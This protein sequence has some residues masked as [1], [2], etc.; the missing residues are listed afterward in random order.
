M[1]LGDEPVVV[2][3]G[4]ASGIGAATATAFAMAGARVVIAD[5]DEAGARALALRLGDGGA[6][7][8]AVR[9]DVSDEADVATLFARVDAA[10]GPVTHLVNNAGIEIVGA[11]QD[12]AVA[13]YDRLFAVNARSVFLC[14][15]EA[16][17]RMIPRR[18]G[19]IVNLASVASFKTWPGDGAYSASK[20]AVLALTKAFAADLAPYAIRVN[21]VAPAIV[22][23]PMTERSLDAEADRAAGRRRREAL[24]PLDRLARPQEIADAIL[25]LAGEES[26]FTTGACL[27]IDGGLLA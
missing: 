20:A 27:T 15:R 26:A 19:A 25:F 21:A 1:R 12:F 16:A 10:F 24:H 8:L 18:R 9:A 23:T 4:A 6:G 7:A 5:R 14:S 13:D 2:V 3:T 17:R 22:D 11:L